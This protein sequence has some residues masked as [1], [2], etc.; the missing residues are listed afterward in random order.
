MEPQTEDDEVR[1]PPGALEVEKVEGAVFS[2]DPK[3]QF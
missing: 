2:T 1:W 3:I